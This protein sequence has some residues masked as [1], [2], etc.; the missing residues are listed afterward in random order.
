MVLRI[1]LLSNRSRFASCLDYWES[2]QLDTVMSEDI[3]RVI[4]HFKK[5]RD[6][7]LNGVI[8]L[9]EN[10][11]ELEGKLVLTD[12]ERVTLDSVASKL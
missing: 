4:V 1:G 5:R 11:A 8:H 2:N 3:T 12:G 6:V 7:A 10:I 9:E